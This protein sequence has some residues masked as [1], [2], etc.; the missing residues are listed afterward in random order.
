MGIFTCLTSG[1]QKCGKTK[2]KAIDYCRN[3]A[4]STNLKIFTRCQFYHGSARERSAWAILSGHSPPSVNSSPLSDVKGWQVRGNSAIIES[5]SVM[6]GE[7]GPGRPISHDARSG[8][9]FLRTPSPV[10]V[11][12][13]LDADIVSRLPSF[14][15]SDDHQPVIRTRNRFST[16]RSSLFAC[17][18]AHA[19]RSTPPSSTD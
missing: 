4:Y 8:L 16:L 14:R 2:F 10:R 17:I 9:C 12:Y 19:S 1:E 7:T 15:L 5:S 13:L 18:G 11:A 6:W 3:R